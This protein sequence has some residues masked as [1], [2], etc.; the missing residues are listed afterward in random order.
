[1]SP[2]CHGFNPFDWNVKDAVALCTYETQWKALTPE[3]FDTLSKEIP[4]DSPISEE[5]T[6][7][8]QAAKS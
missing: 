4:S 3:T 6:T 1:M 5:F 8:M 7:L 2:G